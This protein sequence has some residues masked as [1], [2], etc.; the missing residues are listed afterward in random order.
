[1]TRNPPKPFLSALFTLALML[2]LWAVCS[3]TMRYVRE[4]NPV[5]FREGPPQPQVNHEPLEV[6]G[7]TDPTKGWLK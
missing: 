5:L 1:M 3:L 7:P 2:F 4:Y 6:K